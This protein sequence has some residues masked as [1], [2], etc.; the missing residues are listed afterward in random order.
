MGRNFEK[1]ATTTGKIRGNGKLAGILSRGGREGLATALKDRVIAR[2]T[3]P[4]PLH[5]STHTYRGLDPGIVPS[6]RVLNSSINNLNLGS[7]L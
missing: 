6:I 5:L 7:V 2:G 1:S 3:S 4:I